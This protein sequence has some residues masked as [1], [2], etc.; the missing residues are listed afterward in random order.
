MFIFASLEDRHEIANTSVCRLCRPARPGGRGG[1]PDC[2][3]RRSTSARLGQHPADDPFPWRSARL[4]TASGPR[5]C[6]SAAASPIPPFRSLVAILKR[7]P[8]D[9]LASGPQLAAQVEAASAQASSGR[10]ADI[11]AADRVL[12][13]AW[14][15]LCP[16][17]QAPDRRHVLRLSGAA[18]AGQP[19]GS[20]SAHR[21][22]GSVADPLRDGDRGGKSGLRP[23]ARRRL[24]RSSG[25]RQSTPDLGCSRTSTARGRSRQ[26]ASS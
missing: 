1:C 13:T 21:G 20:D 3:G 11:A 23:A 18:A 16:G 5:P 10:P 17:D 8:F 12:S 25:D 9:G 2:P 15:R 14:V 19:R 6:G 22:R 4:S 7:A 24:G 26:P